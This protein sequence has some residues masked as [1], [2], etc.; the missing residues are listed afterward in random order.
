[1]ILGIGTDISNIDRIE[2]ILKK[3]DARFLDR[4]FTEGERAYVEAV[5]KGDTKRRAAGYAKRWAAKEAGAKALGLGIRDD[6]FLKDIAVVNDAAGAPAL[7]LSGGAKERLTALTPKGMTA[8][9]HVSLS[10]EPPQA[11]AFVIVSAEEE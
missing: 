7:I 1:M 6:V 3:Q 9:I 10:D 5:A 2:D 11:L 8:Y 4:C